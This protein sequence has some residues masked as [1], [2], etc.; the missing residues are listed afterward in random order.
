MGLGDWIMAT[1]Q[2]KTMHEANGR[3]VL[4]M[5]VEQRR[6]MWSPVFENNPRI[7][8]RP[9]PDTRCQILVNGPGAR[10]YIA[11]KYQ[12]RWVWKKWDISPGELF[13]TE[14][15]REFAEPYRD[16]VLIEPHTK[17]ADG[18]K[19]WYWDRWQAVVDET[20][21]H[22]YVQ[23]G[24]FNTRHLRDVEGVPTTFRQAAAILSVARAFLGTEGALH[25]AA[26]AL[27]VPAVVLW[28]E[29]ISPEITGY[30][31]HHNLRHASSSCGAR[32]PCVGCRLSMEMITVEE[33]LQHLEEVICSRNEI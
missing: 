26:A 9:I 25:H 27:S 33:V 3:P 16:C 19:A 10:P 7:A 6:L 21:E 20:P 15:E 17:V 12:E 28:S 1:S 32:V 13:L 14:L 24:P 23:T 22:R 8:R 31:Q 30:E 18:N 11:A 4:V 29:F 5:G 2:V